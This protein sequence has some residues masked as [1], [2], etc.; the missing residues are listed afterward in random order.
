MFTP[1]SCHFR[2]FFSLFF[3]LSSTCYAQRAGQEIAVEPGVSIALANARS[4]SISNIQYQLHFTIPAEQTASVRS[5]ESID[6]ELWE[7]PF[8]AQLK[9]FAAFNGCETIRLTQVSPPKFT[10]AIQRV[11]QE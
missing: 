8:A 6:F 3:L 9:Q 5:T 1:Y 2:A 4:A 7:K 11:L 10:D